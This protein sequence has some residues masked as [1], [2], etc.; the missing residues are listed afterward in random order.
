MIRKDFM[1]LRGSLYRYGNT[2]I[3]KQELSNLLAF[4]VL[5]K[6]Y[7]V[8]RVTLKELQSRER[9]I[10]FWCSYEYNSNTEQYRVV[11]ENYIEL[12]LDIPDIIKE[13]LSKYVLPPAYKIVQNYRTASGTVR[14]S[15][16]WYEETEQGLEF[17]I[18]GVDE[19]KNVLK[20]GTSVEMIK[21]A[22]TMDEEIKNR[23]YAV[24]RL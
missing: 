13:Q 24:P 21:K 2:V 4:A 1:G 10:T 12:C 7:N 22:D 3:V 14:I 23:I 11:D 18:I 19:S 17:A 6:G 5:I 20:V 9:D 16:E 15:A 8:G